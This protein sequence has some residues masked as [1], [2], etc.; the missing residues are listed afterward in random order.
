M[1]KG[2]G[3]ALTIF[4]VQEWR[5]MKPPP[6][7]KTRTLR[8]PITDGQASGHWSQLQ[9]AWSYQT[10]SPENYQAGENSMVGYQGRSPGLG[11]KEQKP[12]R[13]WSD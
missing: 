10:G 8:D 12:P 11:T 4:Q 6:G 7:S 2:R 9:G 1:P 5:E 13:K 3:T